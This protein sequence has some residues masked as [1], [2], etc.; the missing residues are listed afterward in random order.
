MANRTKPAPLGKNTLRSTVL[1]ALL[2][3]WPSAPLCLG[4]AVER[5]LS[6]SGDWVITS[7]TEPIGS[8]EGDLARTRLTLAR[9]QYPLAIKLAS[10]WIEKYPRHALIPEA[11]LVRADAKYLSGDE[12]ESLFDYEAIARQ[13]VG[14]EAFKIAL[15]REYEIAF[16]YANGK[17]RIF[18]GFRIMTAYDEAEELFIRIQER[19][20]GSELARKA[21]RALADYYYRQNEM[22]LAAVAYELYV[23]NNPAAQDLPEATTW[24]IGANLATYKG[25]RHD[26]S[27]LYEARQRL[28]ALERRFPAQAQEIGAEGIRTR[29]DESDARRMLVDAKWYLKRNDEVSCRFVLERLIKR[30]PQTSPAREAYT[31]LK[32]Y[33]WIKESDSGTGFQPVN[34]PETGTTG[35]QP[36]SGTGVSPVSDVHEDTKGVQS[37]HPPKADATSDQQ[38][39]DSTESKEKHDNPIREIKDEGP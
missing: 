18:W 39:T 7:E 38:E 23:E 10:E 31:M 17:K 3:I 13:Y 5:E 22:E 30:Y 14:S 21:G 11:Y 15:D 27:G 12:Y 24:L 4:Q 33:G 8:P 36:V 25:P 1:I 19:M 26:P 37:V 32:D 2:I 29:I 6:D 20:P 35:D 28:D 16:D 34:P 9:K